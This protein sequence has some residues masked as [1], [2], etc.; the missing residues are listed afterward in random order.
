MRVSLNGVQN[1]LWFAY[2]KGLIQG[3]IIGGLA[4][5]LIGGVTLW[6]LK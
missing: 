4:V 2:I 1:L 6:I 5:G 3:A